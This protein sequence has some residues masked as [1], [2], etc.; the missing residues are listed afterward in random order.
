[1]IALAHRTEKEGLLHHQSNPVRVYRD[2][3]TQAGR[4]WKTVAC[5]K[6]QL[7]AFNMRL[8]TKIIELGC[9]SGDVC[10]PLSWQF[11]NELWR[12]C[13][14]GVDCNEACLREAEKRYPQLML[15]LSSIQPHLIDEYEM[16]ILC[17][18]LEHLQNPLD[19]AAGALSKARLSVIS[20][21]LDEPY[22]SQLSAGDHCWS[23]SMQDH[24]DF[25]K[26]GG[27]K[28]DFTEVFQMGMYKIVLS[29][30]HRE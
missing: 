4:I 17:E 29:R 30:G 27:H 12:M 15:R 28:I 20:H 13:V 16:V 23:F 3:T 5:A 7:E 26:V 25:F 11:S 22:G 14:I 18:V 24:E 9:G 8:G 6:A 1:M 2:D 10:G 19:V 21:P